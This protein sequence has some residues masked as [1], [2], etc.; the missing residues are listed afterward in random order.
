MKEL[1]LKIRFDLILWG[2]VLLLA[3]GLRVSALG[4]LPLTDQEAVHTLA[5][6]EST[7]YASPFRVL[8]DPIVPH[9]GAYHSLTAMLFSIFGTTNALA[10]IVPA[11]FGIALVALPLFAQDELG[12][13]RAWLMALLMAVMPSLVTISRSAGGAA[14]GAFGAGAIALS[15][16]KRPNKTEGRVDMWAIAGLACLLSSG[17]AWLHLVIILA[18][19]YGLQRIWHWLGD[20]SSRP[21]FELALDQKTLGITLIATGLLASGLGLFPS[22][23]VGLSTPIGDWLG[24]WKASS[25]L[26]FLPA[27]TWFLSI[28]IYETLIVGSGVLGLVAVLRQKERPSGFLFW[29]SLGATI[30]FLIYPD[31]GVFSIAL[32]LLPWVY[33]AAGFLENLVDTVMSERQQMSFF[34][35]GGLLVILCIHASFFLADLAQGPSFLSRLAGLLN[36]ALA[37]DVSV[38]ALQLSWIIVVLFVVVAMIV[39]VGQGWGWETALRS[40]AV[41]WILILALTNVASIWRLNFADSAASAQELWRSHSTTP[42]VFHMRETL[43]RMSLSSTGT[44]HGMAVQPLTG[45]PAALAWE[46]R[47]FELPAELAPIESE[48]VPAIIMPLNYEGATLPADYV[49]QSLMTHE[50]W[51]WAGVLPPNPIRWWVQ[52]KAPT[53]PDS[54]V[55]LIRQDIVLVGE[56]DELE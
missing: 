2:L 47:Q 7:P 25:E 29:L 55:V 33:F 49:G 28:P 9:S 37:L 54:W 24:G 48:A 5:S 53:L 30:Y 36:S 35:L 56:P 34:V 43:E 8:G 20:R 14:I 6:A 27:W 32:I 45:L 23:L 38:A 46:L 39:V 40:A 21:S 17:I 1:N 51:A 3:A 44:E 50:S 26:N 13:S 15:A 12:R 52:R 18:A 22:G 10:R 31:R 4:G 42:I 41:V 11:L 16:L 19:G